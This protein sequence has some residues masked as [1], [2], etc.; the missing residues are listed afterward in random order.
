MPQSSFDRATAERQFHRAMVAGYNRL[1]REI[2][3]N[4]TY[5]KR[6]VDEKGG[7]AAARQLLGGK[8][9][10]YAEGFTTLWAAQR[11]QLSVEFIALLPEFAP[12]FDER[13]QANARWRLQ[14]HDFDVGSAL[15]RHALDPSFP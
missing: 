4:A 7:L 14:E 12:L 2:G 10:D 11:L 9:E 15:Q 13:E 1:K 5:F 3:Y 6:L 8:R